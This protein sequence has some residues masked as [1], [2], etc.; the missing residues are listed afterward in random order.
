MILIPCWV[1]VG[2]YV[3]YSVVVGHRGGAGKVFRGALG[4]REKNYICKD[5]CSIV[6]YVVI[7]P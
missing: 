1:S 7:T 3:V 6:F 5:R 2:P 4:G